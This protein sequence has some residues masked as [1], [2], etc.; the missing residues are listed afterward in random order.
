[1]HV[2]SNL[3]QSGVILQAGHVSQFVVVR[4]ASF[5]FYFIF[6]SSLNNH[7]GAFYRDRFYRLRGMY[8]HH[9]CILMYRRNDLVNRLTALTSVNACPHCRKKVRQFVAVKCDCRRIRRLL[10][11]SRRFLRQS[12]FSPTVW[13]GLKLAGYSSL[14]AYVRNGNLRMKLL[15]FFV[16]V[17]HSSCCSYLSS[18]LRTISFLRTI[19][20]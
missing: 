2:G 18:L 15:I 20:E 13:T 8:Q 16:R 14:F 6:I 12:H 7:L 1:L 3:S 4:L 19:D 11:L 17:I 10:P 5:V 9:R